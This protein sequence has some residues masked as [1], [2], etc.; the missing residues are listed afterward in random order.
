MKGYS[1]NKE[2]GDLELEVDLIDKNYSYQYENITKRLLN[3]K[4]T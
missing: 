3:K 4:F 2:L 1:L